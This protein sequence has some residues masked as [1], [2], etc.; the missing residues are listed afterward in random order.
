MG[1]HPL[2][3]A[4]DGLGTLGHRSVDPDTDLHLAAV[5]QV[6]GK[7]RRNLNGQTQLA[8]AHPPIKVPIVA[9]RR[10][11]DEV[12]G[13]GQ[14][15]HVIAAGRGLIAIKDSESEV[16]DVEADAVAHYEHQNHAPE[17]GQRAPDRISAQ[18]QRLAAGETEHPPKT[19]ATHTRALGFVVYLACGRTCPSAGFGRVPRLFFEGV[20]QVPDE[21]IVE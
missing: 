15:Q 9:D 16:F 19:E 12:A 2:N 4:A 18:F 3:V 8:G 5:V 1:V 13:T 6:A 17:H 10:V 20:L 21:R 11:F 7:P 14:V